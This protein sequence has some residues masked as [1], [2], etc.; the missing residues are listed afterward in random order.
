MRDDWAVAAGPLASFLPAGDGGGAARLPGDAQCLC[1]EQSPS[2]AMA[3][4]KQCRPKSAPCRS[5]S[6]PEQP[7]RVKVVGLF[8]SSS[9][10][11]AKSA[12]EVTARKP[13]VW[14]ALPVCR[15]RA[16]W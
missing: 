2:A 3:S 7:L 15:S 8:K 4:P 16:S 13:H 14:A 11:V 12:A 6:P 1:S 5:R 9:F 10:Q